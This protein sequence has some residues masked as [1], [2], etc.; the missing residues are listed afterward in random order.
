MIAGIFSVSSALL[1]KVISLLIVYGFDL[2]TIYV[3]IINFALKQI[4]MKEAGAVNILVVLLLIYAVFGIVAAILGYLI[5]KKAI[6]MKNELRESIPEKKEKQQKEFFEI[7]E[8]QKTSLGWL[9]IHLFAVVAG[10]YLVYSPFGQYGYGF[11]GLYIVITGYKYSYSLRRLKKPLFWSQLLIIVILSAI[12]W[13]TGSG[14]GEWFS[15]E[16][17]FVG[18][19]MVLRALFIVMAFTAISV[20]LLNEKV[21]NFLFNVGFGRFYQSVG[22]AF[23][24]LPLMISVLP[25]SKEIIR[26]PL[27]SLLKPLAMAD[28]WL[29][30]F[31]KE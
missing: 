4:G 16:G 6:N 27:R 7:S 23:S 29:E 19:E 9:F 15:T 1:H 25:S 31:R 14:K 10:L 12:F 21:R 28:Q 13:D 8:E 30:M 20:E 17:I 26:H 24:A 2:I 3:N 11:M 5:G 18:L 22:M